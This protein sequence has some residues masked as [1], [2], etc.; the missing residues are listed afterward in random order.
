MGEAQSPSDATSRSVDSLQESKEIIRQK[1][2][3]IAEL[4][5]ANKEAADRV[6]SEASSI[7][8]QK[9]AEMFDQDEIIIQERKRLQHLETQWREQIGEAEIKISKERAKLARDK[10]A[11]DEQLHEI[12][13][14]LAKLEKL[15]NPPRTGKWLDQLGL[16]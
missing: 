7:A 11:L 6:M 13:T 10:T 12:K 8:E 14:Q 16:S 1:D 15:P 2:Q 4:Q 3:L 9:T 5:K